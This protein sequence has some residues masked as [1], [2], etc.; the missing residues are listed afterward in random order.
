MVSEKLAGSSLTHSETHTEV[1]GT[2]EDGVGAWGA[3]AAPHK[4]SSWAVAHD[5]FIVILV[6]ALKTDVLT[7]SPLYLVSRHMG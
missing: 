4:L 7:K 6:I 3:L 1:V 2:F 5:L